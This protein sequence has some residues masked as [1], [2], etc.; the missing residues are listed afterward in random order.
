MHIACVTVAM[1][2]IDFIAHIP[3][4]PLRTIELPLFD[5]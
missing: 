2:L 1:R 4:I 3:H 5:E